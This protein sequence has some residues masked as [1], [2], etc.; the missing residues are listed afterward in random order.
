MEEEWT[1]EDFEEFE[2]LIEE[3]LY[4]EEIFEEEAVEEIF[5]DIEELREEELEEELLAEE[6]MSEEILEETELELVINEEPSRSGIRSEQLN[7]VANSVRA[8]TNSVSGIA[9]GTSSNSYSSGS[10]GST[11]S[12]QSLGNTAASGGIA[13]AT[14]GGIS[15]SSSPSMSDQFASAT[16]QTQQVLALSPSTAVSSDSMS[17]GTDTGSVGSSSSSSSIGGTEVSI[18]PMP[19]MDAGA[20]ATMVDVQVADLSS[21]IDTASTGV[22]TASE[23]DQIADEIIA[24]NIEEQQQQVA[25][26]AEE[27]GEYGDQTALVAFIGFNPNFTGYYDQTLPQKTDWYE[28]REIYADVR[29][30]DNI[31]AFYDMAGT[32]LRTIQGMINSQPNL[33]GE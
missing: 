24:N 19:G 15:T 14:S 18:T 26:S 21:E 12:S 20:S 23:A 1:E 10:G 25:A 17:A 4:A 13:S 8:A 32:S 28:P 16:V 7:V 6:T 3:E 11:V 9:A 27:S 29:L 30:S 22:M 2:E 5:E 31:S 33:L